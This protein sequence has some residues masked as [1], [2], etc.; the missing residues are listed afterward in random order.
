[1]T[2]KSVMISHNNSSNLA[3]ESIFLFCSL[4][5]LES[6]KYV[7]LWWTKFS[8]KGATAS[9]CLDKVLIPHYFI[10]NCRVGD[11]KAVKSSILVFPDCQSAWILAF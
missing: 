11:L 10:G 6:Q 7:T 1:M 3:W 9:G 2:D 5:V 8:F 4:S